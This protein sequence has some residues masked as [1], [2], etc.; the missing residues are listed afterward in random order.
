MTS[1]DEKPRRAAFLLNAHAKSV[2]KVILKRL[3]DII[4]K[5]DLYVSHNLKEAHQSIDNIVNRGYAYLFCGGGDG[6]VVLAIN[7]LN[8]YGKA[9]PLMP[10]PKLGVLRLGTG[11]AIARYLGALAPEHD[12]KA[13]L[14]GKP[15]KPVALSMIET[16]SGQQTPFAG[17][18]YDGE[19]M[20]DFESVKEVFFESP[21]RRFFS[22]VLGY[23]VAGIFKTIPRQFNRKLPNIRVNSSHPAYRIKE[24]NGSDEEVFIETGQLLY[25]GVAPIICVG[26]IPFV[27]YGMTLFPFA[28]RRPG[29]MHL[30]VSAVPLS[31]CLS[32]L[33]PSIWH[34]HFRHKKLFDFLVKDVTIE[35][36]ES[37][38]YQLGGDVMGYKKQLYFKISSAPVAMVALDRKAAPTTFPSQPLMTPLI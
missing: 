2:T 28:N 19:L 20:N 29:Y 23:A 12:I 3:Q 34:G 38:P 31:V 18:G 11:N 17:I 26:T 5:D 30:R 14:A 32:N 24:V 21:F 36:E 37:L 15:I 13:I 8:K 27:G 35:S 4:P 9:H 16:S 25:D 1:T 6:T 22:S 7:Y 33:Y 10:Q